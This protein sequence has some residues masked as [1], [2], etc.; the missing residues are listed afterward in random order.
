MPCLIHRIIILGNTIEMEEIKCNMTNYLSDFPLWFYGN[1]LLN[2]YVNTSISP[3]N[4]YS[5][6]VVIVKYNCDGFKINNLSY[7]T[8]FYLFLFYFI[9]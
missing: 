4:S 1:T 6:I 9:K 7:F 3:M 2:E 5:I 8:L